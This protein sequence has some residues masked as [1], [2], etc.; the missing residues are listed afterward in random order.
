MPPSFSENPRKNRC[1]VPGIHSDSVSVYIHGL[2]CT[3]TG[4]LPG[5]PD[6]SAAPLSHPPEHAALD[7]ASARGALPYRV[8]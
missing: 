2:L 7:T 1:F 3:G 5:L 8:P 4:V 6:I